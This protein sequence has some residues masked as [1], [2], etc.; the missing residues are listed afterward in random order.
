MDSVSNQSDLLNMKNESL[1]EV[2][3][4]SNSKPSPVSLLDISLALP[5][6]TFVFILVFYL[7]IISLAS[8]GCLLVIYVVLRAKNLRTNSNFYLVNLAVSDLLL[9]FL[10]CP[11]TLAQLATTH[12]PFPSYEI[13]CKLATFLPLLFS[14]ASTFTICLIALDRHQLIVHTHNPRHRTLITFLCIFSVWT[15]AIACAFPTIPNTKLNIVTLD[16]SIF[17]ILGIKE[18]AYCMENWGYQHGR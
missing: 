13:L 14:F 3:L 15:I 17:L 9:V 18:R 11:M 2:T 8:F 16:P 5:P 10:A 12:W 6:V 4:L 1:N 7:L